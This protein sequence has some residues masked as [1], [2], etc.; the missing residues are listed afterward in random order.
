MDEALA[1]VVRRRAGACWE[2]CRLPQAF[3]STRFQIDHIIAEQHGGRA[4]TATLPG[5]HEIPSLPEGISWYTIRVMID[6]RTDVRM[7][8]TALR[9][10]RVVALLGP[11]WFSDRD[12]GLA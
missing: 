7:L 3:S 8:N 6:R 12:S 9:R 1:D 2:Y 4:V 10:S 11:R 5:D